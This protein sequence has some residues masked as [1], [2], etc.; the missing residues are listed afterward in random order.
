M[1]SE[2]ID[3]HTHYFPRDNLEQ[4][5]RD[6]G[7][8]YWLDLLFP[9]KKKSLQDL[10]SKEEFIAQMDRANIDKAVINGAYYQSVEA[11][12]YFNKT[13]L[14]FAKSYPD[15]ILPMAT[16]CP[17][18]VEES[19]AFL[20]QARGLGFVAVGELCDKVQ[21]FDFLSD[22][23][24]EIVK[25][26]QAEELPICIH[27][28]DEL[29]KDYK[30]KIITDNEALFA[31]AKKFPKQK[32]IFSHLAGG[33]AFRASD[34]A[35]NIYLDCAAFPLLYKESDW[36]NLDF[37]QL[38]NLCFGTDYSLALYPKISLKADFNQLKEEAQRNIPTKFHK[39]I[40]SQ[41]AKKLFNL[42]KMPKESLIKIDVTPKIQ[43]KLDKIGL[44]L[45]KALTR[46]KS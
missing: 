21:G 42:K 23:F 20:K 11:C 24:C 12:E 10:V 34:F 27:L 3:I 1:P 30:G 29:G 36:A 37:N 7:E 31:L 44:A 17:K 38:K 28:S 32:F 41:N 19:I 46:R 25:I 4:V 45:E 22:G 35:E 6:F 14:D 39:A 2:I 40:F 43:K 5:L 8:T 18:F 33:R 9:Q 16:I 26:C 13:A 15:R